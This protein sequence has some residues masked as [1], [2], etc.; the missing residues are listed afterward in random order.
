MVV[1]GAMTVVAAGLA[2][3]LVTA[4][5]AGAV[6]A[7]VGAPVLFAVVDAVGAAVVAG[8]VVVADPDGAAGAD[9]RFGFDGNFAAA[10]PALKAFSTLIV[11]PRTILAASGVVHMASIEQIQ[12]MVPVANTPAPLGAV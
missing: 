4:V 11:T 6:V 10:G 5:V 9:D 8:L 3:V 7:V 2:V 1:V 12:R